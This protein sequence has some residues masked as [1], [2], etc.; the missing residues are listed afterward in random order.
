MGV[1]EDVYT[2]TAG[3]QVVTP[4]VHP[5]SDGALRA[6]TPGAQIGPGNQADWPGKT[7]SLNNTIFT[8][9]PMYGHSTS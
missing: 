9:T 7:A 6:C 1:A 5:D 4:S 8:N 2:S 3:T